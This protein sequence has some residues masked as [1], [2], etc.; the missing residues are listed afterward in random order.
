MGEVDDGAGGRVGCL[1][2]VAGGGGD[3]K[4]LFYSLLVIRFCMDEGWEMR[5]SERL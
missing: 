2:W 5:V 4:G 3:A 1:G